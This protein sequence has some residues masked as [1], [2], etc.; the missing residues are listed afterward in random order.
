M[1]VVLFIFGMVIGF[2]IGE[3]I[4]LYKLRNVFK[5]LAKE[6]N[7]DI[8]DDLEETEVHIIKI[9]RLEVE[10]INDI[11]YLYDRSNDTFV[12]QAN[13][14]EELAKLC[15]NYKN[16]SIATVIHQDK[17]FIFQDGMVEEYKK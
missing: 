3:G 10:Q 4:T 2:I 1:E 6:N 13:T 5:R 16:I 14:L 11:L 17:V 9:G 15:K 8:E 12:C 7:I